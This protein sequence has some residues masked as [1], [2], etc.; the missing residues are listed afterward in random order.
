MLAQGKTPQEI[1][2]KAQC[3]QAY[4]RAV[5][6]RRL[7]GGMTDAER[8]W[9]EANPDRI[10]VYRQREYQNLR[11][12]PKKWSKE[13]KRSAKYQRERYARDPAFRARCLELKRLSR[14]RKAAEARA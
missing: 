12:D 14:Q 8:A 3:S 9:R 4:V 7:A 13:K 6:Q 5:L 2:A 11:A 1:G 10:R